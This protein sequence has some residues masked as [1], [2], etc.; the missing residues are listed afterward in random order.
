V[1]HVVGAEEEIAGKDMTR[2]REE[3]LQVD[4]RSKR[5][6]G[7]RMGVVGI[8]KAGEDRGAVASELVPW[9]T[10]VPRQRTRT[11]QVA[12][13]HPAFYPA[14]PKEIQIL[15]R[16]SGSPWQ[17]VHHLWNYFPHG[18]AWICARPQWRR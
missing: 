15:Q 17:D 13:V 1:M 11:C 10:E 3:M 8:R 5:H 12:E 7:S 4:V 9:Q 16:C 6:E 18:W 14:H 2:G